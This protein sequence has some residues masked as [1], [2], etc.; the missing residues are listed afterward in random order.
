MRLELAV[1]L[2]ERR[3]RAV[4]AAAVV[5]L[6]TQG[7]TAEP[8][9][10]PVRVVSSELEMV[11]FARLVVSA[12][13]VAGIRLAAEAYRATFLEHLRK[14]GYPAVGA[15]NL[16]FDRDLSDKARY[17]IGGNV[18]QISCVPTYGNP[19]MRCDIAV[20]WELFDRDDERVTYRVATRHTATGSDS[21]LMAN[22]L[23]WGTFFSLLSRP[24]FVNALRKPLPAPPAP[25]PPK[26]AFRR[27][28][29]APL[30]MPAASEDVLTAT[31][32]IMSGSRLGSGVVISPDGLVLTAAH[33]VSPSGRTQV[34]VQKGNTVTAS[35]IRTDVAD[36]VALLKMDTS[37]PTACL[38]LRQEEARVG[39][40]VYAI[41]SPLS[42]SL[43]FTLTRGIVSG[44]RVIDG[45][46][47]VQTDATVNR[48]NSGGPL[49]DGAGRAV[50]IVR[51]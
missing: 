12:P 50:A 9:H 30:S 33:V 6:S 17:A 31:A 40:E 18:T 51:W 37:P 48:G 38:E 36:D 45:K 16:V 14:L 22:E 1:K 43:A 19:A 35:V 32:M 20:E 3:A 46:S 39:E 27:C 7:A 34:Q 41:G 42:T 15:E 13:Q 49:I 8:M 21:F 24:R 5:L 10:T 4:C 2:A 25:P 28:N 11:T 23:V 44:I 29:G 26:A 47:Y